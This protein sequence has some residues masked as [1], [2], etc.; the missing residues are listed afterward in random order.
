M[1]RKSQGLTMCNQNS[2]DQVYSFLEWQELEKKIYLSALKQC[3]GKVSGCGAAALLD[4]KST[5]LY[6]RIKKLGL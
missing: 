6:S 5:M 1:P 3:H 2:H 4:F